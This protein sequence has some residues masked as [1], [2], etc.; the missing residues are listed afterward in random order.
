MEA[1]PTDQARPAHGLQ[2]TAPERLPTPRTTPPPIGRRRDHLA[3]VVDF[4][5]M[6]AGPLGKIEEIGLPHKITARSS[7][8][9]TAR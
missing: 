5:L 4:A 3:L 2:A 6:R 8:N 7:A 1:I 9:I